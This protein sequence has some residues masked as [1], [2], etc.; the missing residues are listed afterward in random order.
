VRAGS[1][2]LVAL[3]D[4]SPDAEAGRGLFLVSALVERVI[5]GLKA[6]RV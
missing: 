2:A 5:Q 6:L 4:S 1:V 3:R